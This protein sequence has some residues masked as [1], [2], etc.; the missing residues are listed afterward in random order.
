MNKLL[1]PEA[2]VSP[3]REAH[4]R[5]P[6]WLLMYC[7][8][9]VGCLASLQADDRPPNIVFFF[10]DDQT[11]ST[12]GCY[13]HPFVQTPN[14][15]ALAARGTRFSQALVSHSI[16][17]VSRTTI[18]SGLTGRSYG[19][20]GQ[21]DLARP[22]AVTE[23][24]PD[25]LRKSG[26]RTGFFGKW[27]AKMPQGYQAKDHFDVYRPVGRNP[28]YK[29]QPDGSLRHETDLIVDHAIAFLGEQAADQPFAINLW[30]NACH[31]E[32]G[33]RRP[34][35][36]QFPWPQS[37]NGLYEDLEMPRPRL[38]APEIFNGLPSFLKTTIN[39]ERYFWRWNTDEKYQI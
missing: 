6:V 21:R 7:V 4:W 36:G 12:I 27:H 34:G 25:L 2:I 38:D 19:T 32:D 31:A 15:D 33:D 20:P 13:G 22:E 37:S 35:I 28:F 14:I 11:T 26:Y 5:H 23:L 8:A 24:Y 39:R 18:L 3:I 1:S 9:W 29:K 16:C 30:F 10:A 17:W